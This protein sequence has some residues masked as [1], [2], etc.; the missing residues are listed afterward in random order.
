MDK[1]IYEFTE[2]GGSCLIYDA[3]PPRYWFNYLWNENG[4]CAQISQ[5]GHGRSYYLNEKADMCMINNNDARYLYIRDEESGECWNIGAGPLNTKVENYRCEHSIGYSRIQ[6][7]YSRIHGSWR[8]YCTSSHPFA[9]HKRYNAFLVSSEPV[10]AYD[11]DLAKFCGETDSITK[12]D[13]SAYALFQSPK[14]VVEGMDYTNST[15]ALFILG[16]SCS[17]KLR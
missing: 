15:A 3:K 9:P 7:D 5:M 14:V 8:F 11:G 16:A 2:D 4:Y 6:S 13:A 17:I 12:L 10:F 1:R